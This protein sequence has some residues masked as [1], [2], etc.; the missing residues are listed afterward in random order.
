MKVIV[1]LGF[2][3][4]Y[5]ASVVKRFSH[6]TTEYY[7]N[8]TIRLFIAISRTFVAGVLLL[9]REAVSVFYSPSRLS[10]SNIKN[11]LNVCKQ[12]SS[13]IKLPTKQSLRTFI[14]I[15]IYIYMCVCVYIYA[16]VYECACVYVCVC[17]NDLA[18]S[19]HYGSICHR[20]KL[21]KLI[22]NLLKM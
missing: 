18:L 21:P 9:Y 19:N 16:G 11:R 3:L 2:E 4:P 1:R 5:Y 13:K 22:S 6:Y 8:L 7:R 20:N 14:Y 15:Y 10:N 17:K 12:M